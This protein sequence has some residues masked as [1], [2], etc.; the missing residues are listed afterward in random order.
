MD[1]I[2]L[3]TLTSSLTVLATESAKGLANTTD[4]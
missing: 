2:T 3:A 4:S 1:P